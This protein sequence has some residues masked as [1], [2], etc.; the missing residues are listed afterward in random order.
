MLD[1]HRIDGASLSTRGANGPIAST[2]STINVFVRA[3]RGWIG[4]RTRV[5]FTWTGGRAGG[6]VDRLKQSTT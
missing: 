6:D 4:E 1:F 5:L 2:I 3:D